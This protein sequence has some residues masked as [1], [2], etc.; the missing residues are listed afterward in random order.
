MTLLLLVL[1]RASV[2]QRDHVL[3]QQ[4]RVPTQHLLALLLHELGGGPP[5]Q[6]LLGQHHGAW[7]QGGEAGRRVRRRLRDQP[8][9]IL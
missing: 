3:R 6:A 5:E 2:V 9:R 7:W 4:P 1:A 8:R